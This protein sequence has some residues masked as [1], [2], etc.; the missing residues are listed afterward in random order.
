MHTRARGR[1]RN[2]GI[3][4]IGRL[5]VTAVL[6]GRFPPGVAVANGAFLRKIFW[7]I[8]VNP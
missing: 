6:N 4:C 1:V 3:A 5:E 2:Y 8:C 7:S